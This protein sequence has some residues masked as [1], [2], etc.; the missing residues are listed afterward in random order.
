VVN[1]RA[2]QVVIVSVPSLQTG[3]DVVGRV[4]IGNTWRTLPKSEV[5]EGGVL[6]L[7]ALT[8][9]KAGTYSVKLSLETGGSRYVTV[10]VKK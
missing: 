2:N 6:T 8:F 10:K 9:S 1:A 3:T 7:P 4:K 5:G